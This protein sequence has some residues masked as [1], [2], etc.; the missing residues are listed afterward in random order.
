MNDKSC[1]DCKFW[2]T[3]RNCNTPE[4]HPCLFGPPM[5]DPWGRDSDRI[6]E[7]R[8]PWM[9]ADEFCFRWGLMEAETK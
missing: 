2:G 1:K 9:Y 4:F 6:R 7:G 5:I 8:F 3:R